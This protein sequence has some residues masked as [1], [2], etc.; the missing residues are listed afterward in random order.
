MEVTSLDEAASV[1]F[2]RS[3]AQVLIL[4]GYSDFQAVL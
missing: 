4:L 1:L 2:N 3:S